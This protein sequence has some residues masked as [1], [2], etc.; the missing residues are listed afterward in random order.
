[1]YYSNKLVDKLFDEALATSDIRRRKTL[2]ARIQR[3]LHD[4]APTLWAAE[5]DWYVTRRNVVQGFVWNPYSIGV[6]DYYRL[7]LSK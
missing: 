7:W 3:I 4:D 1:M 5:V 6:P 2:Y